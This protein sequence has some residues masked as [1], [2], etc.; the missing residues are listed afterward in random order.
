MLLCVNSD[1]SDKQVQ[2]VIGKSPKPRCFKNVIKLPTKYHTNGKAWMMTETFCSFLRSL[3]VQMGAQNRQILLFVDN[4]AAH[5]K[6][7]PFLRN[8]KVVRYPTN[9]TSTLQPLDLGI[10]HSLKAYHRKRLVQTSICLMKSGEEVKKNIN[11][12]EA[13]HYIMAA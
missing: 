8:I 7:T 3:D 5:P 1:G 6:Y 13:L 12:L 4:C 9:C 10:I 11:I 2:T